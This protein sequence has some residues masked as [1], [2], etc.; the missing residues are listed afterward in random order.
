MYDSEEFKRMGLTVWPVGGGHFKGKGDI[1]ERRFVATHLIF[2]FIEKGQMRERTPFGEHLC[3]A[4]QVIAFWPMEWRTDSEP[5]G[6]AGA[7]FFAVDGPASPAVATCFGMSTSDRVRGTDDPETAKIL[8]REIVTAIMSPERHGPA[9]FLRRFYELAER[10]AAETVD[11]RASAPETLARKA[12]RL[13]HSSPLDRLTAAGLAETLEV[14]Q[15]TLI[16]ACRKELGIP[17]VRLLIQAKM[18]KA[19][20]LLKTSALPV[21][22]VACACGF[23]SPSRFSACFKAEHGVAPGEYRDK[24]EESTLKT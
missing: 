13:C 22:Q 12:V 9:H 10:C 2:S 18:Q 19:R 8:C 6:E 15:N 24:P 14:S 16:K 3:R 20:Q 4:G 11:P 17:P 7:Y 21:N 1:A 5:A 23:A